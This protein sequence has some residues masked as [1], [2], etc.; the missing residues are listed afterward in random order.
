M[1]PLLW[2]A[3]L[4]SFGAL[5]ARP[6]PDIAL[7][8]DDKGDWQL[9]YQLTA[10][11]KQLRFARSPDH[12]RAARWQPLDPAF[13]IGQDQD[14]EY[15]ARKDGQAFSS[16]AIRLTPTYIYL[17]KDYA[18]FSPFSDGGLALHSGRFFACVGL[19]EGD[20][21]WNLS[22][23][24]P[25]GDH[26]VSRDG[27][28]RQS[29]RWQDGGEGQVLYVGPLQPREGAE[30]R[31][32][33]DP[34][35]P[36][37]LRQALDEALPRILAHYAKALGPARAKPMLIASFGRTMGGQYGNQGGVLANQISMHWYGNQLEKL[38]AKPEQISAFLWFFAHEGAHFYQGQAGQ[39]RA[40]Q[41]SWLHEGGA[42]W[43]AMDAIRSLYPERSAFTDQKLEDARSQCLAGLA[44][45]G[46]EQ[47]AQRGLFDLY[48]SCGLALYQRLAETGTDPVA[49]WRRYKAAV[50]KGAE[51]G[52]Q[53]WL[54]QLP[55]SQAKV[56][57]ALLAAT[58]P[59]A[60]PAWRH[61][62]GTAP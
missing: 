56:L 30:L 7:S 57:A 48:Y 35:L 39:V 28:G 41:D 36:P 62:L 54:A 25:K 43:L 6:V 11:A 26:I 17:P 40:Q 5:A 12:S 61:W 37:A 52:R 23:A 50:A 24:A 16:A 53:V 19:C 2:L 55:P 45:T 14:G 32:L 33:V 46:L 3:A 42:E 47:A 58:P 1:K 59:E 18:P 34:G 21:H 31:A 51:P 44:Q 60:A 38:L 15:L 29:L 13:Q 4:L 8:K 9:N 22:L 10:P 20:E 49:L 27:Q